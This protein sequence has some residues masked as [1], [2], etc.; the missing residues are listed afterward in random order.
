MPARLLLR[1]LLAVGFLVGLASLGHAEPTED[2]VIALY[3]RANTLRAEGKNDQA[4]KIFLRI[5]PDTARLWGE[6]SFQHT[7]IMLALG[8][9]YAETGQNEKAET[10]YRRCLA[11]REEKMGK[12]HVHVANVLNNLALL[13]TNTLRPR[14]A[15]PLYK[16]AVPIF[17][18]SG[19]TVKLADV[20]NN[21]G[22]LYQGIG[23]P[24]EGEPLVLRALKIREDRVPVD[25]ADVA[26]SCVT[27]ANGYADTGRYEKAEPYYARAIKFWEGIDRQHP[28]LAIVLESQAALYH[29]LGQNDK[30]EELFQR[31]LKIRQALGE[32]HPLVA[33]SL[34][35]LGK[36]YADSG[37]PEK[38]E[39]LYR[40]SLEI[41]EATRGKDYPDYGQTLVN[42]AAVYRSTGRAEKAVPLV[43]QGQE[44]LEKQLGKNHPEVIHALNEAACLHQA[45]GDSEAAALSFDRVR[46]GAQYH[47]SRVLPSLGERE[48]LD[49]LRRT[50][51]HRLHQALSLALLRSTDADLSA[52]SAEWL[53]NAKGQVQETRA[54]SI[55]AARDGRD[56]KLAQDLRTLLDLRREMGQVTVQGPQPGQAEAHKKRLAELAEKEQALTAKLQAQG[57]GVAPRPWIELKQVQDALPSDGVFLDFAKFDNQ[58]FAKGTAGAA[59]YAVWIT[60]K[61]GATRVVDLG[62]A[63]AIDAAIVQVRKSLEAAEKELK[64]TGEIKAEKAVRE[65][66]RALAKL[67]ID[68]VLPHAGKIGRWVIGPDGGLWLAP[69]AALPVG[70]S[71]LVE[72]HVLQL[73]IS[74]RDLLARPALGGA[75]QAPAIFADPDFQGD[76]P[77]LERVVRGLSSDLKLGRIPRLPGTAAEAAAVVELIE[78]VFGQAPQVLIEEKATV[79]AFLALKRPR[80]LTLATH[81]FF[82]EDNAG[83][84]A[85][86]PLLRCGLLLAGCNKPGDAGRAGVLTGRE[87]LSADLRG[88][89]LVVLSACQTGLGDVRNGEGVAGLRQAFQLAGA[90]SVL[91]SL[92]QVPDDETTLQMV[93]LMNGL[94]DGGD[95]AEALAQA[96]RKRISQR[97]EKFGAAHPLNWAAF[98]LTGAAGTSRPRPPQPPAPAPRP[99][100]GTDWK[101]H[102]GALRVKGETAPYLRSIPGERRD[103]WRKLAE[104][105]DPQAMIL[106]GDCVEEGVGTPQDDAL[107]VSWY[108]K[109]S[110]AGNARGMALLGAAYLRGAGVGRD[111]G[112][113][114]ELLEKA[115]NAGDEFGLFQL[116]QCY[117]HGLGVKENAEKAYRLFCEAAEKGDSAAMNSL[118]G[119]YF[120]GSGVGEDRREACRWFHA[121]ARNG[122]TQAQFE[123]ANCFL[124]GLG[125]E[126]DVQEGVRWMRESAEKGHPTAQYAVG[127]LYLTGVGVK[128]DRAEAIRWFRKAAKAG[129]EQA[130]KALEKLGV[131]RE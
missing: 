113:A 1:T 46:R 71:Y 104:Q 86:D 16:R 9:L 28:K 126:K 123:V 95:R 17:E 32:N 55:L 10:H 70:D 38:A 44:I 112:R 101:D 88:C 80:A 4:E 68:P 131:P 98:T 26:D 81:G 43:R 99:N 62:P 116:A 34:N 85:E 111:P 118:G 103:L 40:R 54:Q 83:T 52:R 121:A 51:V 92:W 42:L 100:L 11:L 107:A 47:A 15:E 7:G 33:T 61:K 102:Q 56:P 8:T 60:P 12:E 105:G 72:Q 63:E 77:P 2:E 109:A 29:D 21:L 114:V 69:W 90:D 119:C 36:V 23:R 78:K 73:V 45:A 91:A 97:R 84:L 67:V 19:D 82:L 41:T 39:P 75:R 18:K 108:R 5:L 129:S 93:A 79:A 3:R 37:K 76:A 110:E 35:N 30:A 59:R 117:R 49:F 87:V 128:Q 125:T 57:T 124:Q 25:E 66:L 64:A 58:D 24:E 96:Q 106:W 127:D 6:G 20:L 53:V 50:D 115:G 27:L 22:T 120:R 14:E 13:L 122:H 31:S 48:Q 130:I 65:P 74:G 94:V 89:E